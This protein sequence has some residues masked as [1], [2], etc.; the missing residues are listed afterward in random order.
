M[1]SRSSRA[2]SV[3]TVKA[4]RW[5]SWLMTRKFISSLPD[6]REKSRSLN[7]ELPGPDPAHGDAQV[8]RVGARPFLGGYEGLRR[9][10][11]P[12]DDRAGKRA[13]QTERKDVP[14]AAPDAKA[15]QVLAFDLHPALNAPPRSGFP[16]DGRLDEQVPAAA[17]A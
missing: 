14:A 4:S 17:G 6:A 16:P 12:A 5:C 11:A 10:E 7:G 2:G 3:E 13:R 9:D 1:A 15:P 8:P